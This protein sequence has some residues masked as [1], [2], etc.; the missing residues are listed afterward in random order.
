MKNLLII[1]FVISVFRISAQEFAPIGSV[2][3]YDQGTPNPTLITFET[4]ESIS[5]TIINTI[6]CRKLI[7]T[8]RY[9]GI[10]Q[11]SELFMYS[12]N[13]SVF[14]YANNE[15]NLLYNFS[16]AT[17]DTVTLGYFTNHD[18]SPLKMII[19][20]T[21]SITING[22]VRKIQYVTCGDG[23]SIEFGGSVIS[24]IGN[25]EYMFPRPDGYTDG[26]LRCYNDSNTGLFINQNHPDNGWNFQDCEQ[27]ITG[28]E[29]N[30]Q[31]RMID[32]FPN[33]ST[34]LITIFRIDTKTNYLFYDY[35][36]RL[37][38]QGYVLPSES[39]NVSDLP[40]GIYSILL[41]NNKIKTIS[42]R[43]IKV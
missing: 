43:I 7:R 39:I 27:T 16:A 42:R 32:I 28:I 40:G 30:S 34:S 15:F 12:S 5:D 23:I 13:D 1:F 6:N 10:P 20:S 22:H 36:G 17:D 25:S 11:T 29:E 41:I 18:G 24:G 8:S 21:G 33:P 19:D 9:A 35:L 38:K 31:S 3:H 37:I 26:P 14:Y 2:W 4:I